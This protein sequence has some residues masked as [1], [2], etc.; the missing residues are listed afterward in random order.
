MSALTEALVALGAGG[1]ADARESP[2]GR[3]RLVWPP[4]TLP[5]LLFLGV[6]LLSLLGSRLAAAQRQGDRQVGLR[7]WRSSLVANEMD[8]RWTGRW[9]FVLLGTGA[10]VA[11][12]GIYQFLFQVGPEGFVLFD[13]FMRAYGTFEQPNPYAGYLGLTLPLAVGLV[14]A[15]IASAWASRVRELVGCSGQPAPGC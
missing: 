9:F 3:S 12:H 7:S 4:L 5:L 11:L 6:L 10:L 13:R 14:V 15:W 2:V 8:G 1:L